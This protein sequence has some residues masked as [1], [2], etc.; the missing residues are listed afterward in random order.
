MDNNLIN[1]L[2]KFYDLNDHEKQETLISILNLANDNPEKF[3]KAIQNEKFNR[4]NNLPIIYEALSKDLDNWADFF[5]T[6]IERLFET[7]KQSNTPYSILNHLQE[8]TFID[9]DKFKHRDRIVEILATQLD[10]E[11]STFRF[12]ALDLLPDFVKD[13][14]ML[15]IN[16]MKKLLKDENW[17]IRYWTYLNLKDIGVLDEQNDKLSWTDRLRSKFLNNLKFQ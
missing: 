14:D 11:N 6:E 5:I 12:C 13:D 15:T 2:E 9:P 10:N 3:I 8:F 17:R 1:K 16:K 7:A 4:L